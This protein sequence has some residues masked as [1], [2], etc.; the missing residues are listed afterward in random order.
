[1]LLAVPMGSYTERLGT[2]RKAWLV[3]AASG[4]HGMDTIAMV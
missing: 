1:M 4:M 3:L 2:Q